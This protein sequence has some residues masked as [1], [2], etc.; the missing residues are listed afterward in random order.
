MAV[1]T[2]ELVSIKQL[3]G[4]LKFGKLIRWNLCVIIKRLFISHQIQCSMKGLSTLRLTVTLSEKRY[5]QEILLRNL[6]SQMI[7]LQI[8]SPSPSQVLILIT[9]VTN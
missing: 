9:F 4:E 1:A 8:S 5:S 6:R 2:C 7:S 3:L